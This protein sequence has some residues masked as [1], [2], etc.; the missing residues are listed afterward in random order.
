MAR[1][2]ELFPL[3]ALELLLTSFTSENELHVE[4]FLSLGFR[5]LL[6]SVTHTFN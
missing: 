3:A 5:L 1:P 4:P 2:S 6:W